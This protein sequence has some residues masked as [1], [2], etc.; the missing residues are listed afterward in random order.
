M[1]SAYKLRIPMRGY[2]EMNPYIAGILILGYESPC[3]VMRLEGHE[4]SMIS[5][6]YE[7]PCGVMR[8]GFGPRG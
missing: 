4:N 2:E 8:L 7:S 3:G 6:C 1:P 5:V